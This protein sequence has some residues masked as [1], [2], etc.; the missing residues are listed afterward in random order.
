MTYFSRQNLT[1]RT[2][3]KVAAAGL[4]TRAGIADKAVASEAESA[5]ETFEDVSKA[6][7][8]LA[9]SPVVDF[10]THFGLWQ[11]MGLP[12]SFVDPMV[13]P[14]ST[15]RLDRN[16]SEHL[17]GGVNCVYLDIV[18]DV[19]LTRLGR[20]GNK[21]R[22]FKKGEAWRE[23]LRQY[24]I[25]KSILK[26]DRLEFLQSPKDI[27]SVSKQGNLG[28]F[29]STEGGHMIEDDP[30]KLDVM[31]EHGLRR[32]Q[33]IHYVST[34]IGDNQTDEK[35][36]GGLSATGKEI[37][38]R[39]TEKGMMLDCAHA[40]F[41]CAAQMAELYGKPLALSHTMMHYMSPQYGAFGKAQRSRWISEDH[42]RMIASTGGV[43]GTFPIKAPWGVDTL[44]QFVELVK[45]MMDTVGEDHV[46]WSTDLID[47]ARPNFLPS[48][49]DLPFIAQAMLKSGFDKQSI[50]KFFGYNA[51][52]VH[53]ATVSEPILGNRR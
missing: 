34:T 6:R 25:L 19:M 18:S 52:R 48:Y 14:M 2:F 27:P 21:L 39:I 47:S 26:K 11:T 36:Y 49:K 35:K 40:S 10:H 32:I 31:F 38:K 41:A 46:C 43:I 53:E 17:A 22:D 20:P 4:V 7:A 50:Q 16:I 3:L 51:L 45:V 24:D 23:Y 13:K 28:V 15:H 1:R 37:I 29:F 5:A 44:D 8:I 42:A 9:A 12:I 33:P 30:E